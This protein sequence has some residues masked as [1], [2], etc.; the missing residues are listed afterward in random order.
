M[1]IIIIQTGAIF[2]L[3]NE[4]G[5]YWMGPRFSPSEQWQ[6]PREP[7]ADVPCWL[8]TSWESAEC[9]AAL[10][11]CHPPESEWS[12]FESKLEEAIAF[13]KGNIN[14]PH[15]IGNAVIACLVE[16]RNAARAAMNGDK[17]GE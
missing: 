4:T 11:Q 8:T 10:L 13:H 12:C 7:G 3:R 2:S 1:K 9:Q 14:D 6:A 5:E 15:G 16:I 17:F